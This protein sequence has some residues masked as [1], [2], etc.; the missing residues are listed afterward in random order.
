MSQIITIPSLTTKEYEKILESVPMPYEGKDK[1]NSITV[2][3]I[4]QKWEI[5]KKTRAFMKK[6]ENW[7]MRDEFSPR[8]PT[9][10]PGCNK[11]AKYI[12]VPKEE[13]Q[14]EYLMCYHCGETTHR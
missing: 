6:D 1:N 5:A 7:E 11:S 12:E 2:W 9:R 10:C 4:N 13:G 3:I 8:I 14:K